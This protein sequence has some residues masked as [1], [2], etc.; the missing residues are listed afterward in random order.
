[1]APLP[2][3]G[4]AYG[5]HQLEIEQESLNLRPAGQILP[6]KPFHPACKDTLSILKNNIISKNLLIW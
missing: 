1:M 3:P 5:H 6:A 4:Y 2:P